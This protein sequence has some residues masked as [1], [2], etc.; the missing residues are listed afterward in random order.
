M[1]GP[2]AGIKQHDRARAPVSLNTGVLDSRGRGR[3]GPNMR[4]GRGGRGRGRYNNGNYFGQPGAATSAPGADDAM[5]ALKAQVATWP[6]FD[7]TPRCQQ[8][9]CVRTC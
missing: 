5:D 7:I 4:G 2:P 6:T 8:R 9:L 3:G 1:A